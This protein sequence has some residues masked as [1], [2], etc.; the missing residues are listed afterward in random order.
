M[1]RDSALNRRN[2][3]EK[4]EKNIK[5]WTKTNKYLHSEK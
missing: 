3:N 4:R 1:L 5:T 2:D